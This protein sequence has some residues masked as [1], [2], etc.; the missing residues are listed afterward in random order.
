MYQFGHVEAY[1]RKPQ[2]GGWNVHDI[3]SEAE[4]VPAHCKH[5]LMAKE[6][7]RVF[8]CS[9][10][11]AVVL[12]EAWGAQAKDGLGRKL[13]SDA[14][15]LLAGILSYPK[16]G[17]EWS[18][19]KAQ[20]LIWLRKTYGS[21]LKSVVVH[22]DESHPHLHF[23][24]VP[25]F[26]QDFNTL[27]PG[28]AAAAKAKRNGDQKALQQRA[29][30]EAMRAWQDRLYLE[31]G[32]DFGLARIGPKRQR[33]T[34]REW[35]A[36][37]AAQQAILVAERAT[38][39]EAVLSKQQQARVM[40]HI[41]GRDVG[42]L[43]KQ[44]LYDRAELDRVRDRAFAEGITVQ[45]GRQGEAAKIVAERRIFVS[46]NILKIEG[47]SKNIQAHLAEQEAALKAREGAVA[48][49]EQQLQAWA[50][51]LTDQQREPLAEAEA[52]LALARRRLEE[53]QDREKAL[54]ARIERAERLPILLSK[55]RK[56]LRQQ[57]PEAVLELIPR[58]SH[59]YGM[60]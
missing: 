31:L 26:G 45:M 54:K 58:Q 28:R 50:V 60:G 7:I 52:K 46:E 16:D 43:R 40:L 30:N 22:Q 42:L 49:Q 5:V 57:L 44:R 10:K 27:H 33:L 11:E 19:F 13:R 24:A 34:R 14:P 56:E 6:P 12:A 4:R 21:A 25:E 17:Q 59:G 38:K 36:Q 23:Y 37:Q 39:A 29:H 18:A 15:V 51:Q 35:K 41:K 8:G 1:A 2:K 9:P 47:D 48:Y 53:S 20:A 3:A 32:R 55:L